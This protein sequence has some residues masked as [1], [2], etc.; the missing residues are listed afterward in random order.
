MNI[1]DILLVSVYKLIRIGNAVMA[2][3]ITDELFFR[4]CI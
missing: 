1:E 4:R 3:F 2:I